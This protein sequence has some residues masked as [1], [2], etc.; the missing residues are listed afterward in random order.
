M[1]NIIFKSWK[2][3]KV[4]INKKYYW[5][6]CPK[7]SQGFGPQIVPQ[8]TRWK[9]PLINY[10]DLYIASYQPS[11]R[12]N[13]GQPRFTFLTRLLSFMRRSLTMTIIFLRPRAKKCHPRHEMELFEI[14][15]VKKT[16]SENKKA[17]AL[18]KWYC[19]K[20]HVLREGPEI[21]KKYSICF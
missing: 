13:L 8:P 12:M 18:S 17:L 15:A 11:W 21:W 16:L 7:P 19:G 6:C 20:V 10:P 2:G 4:E 5:N 3:A 9:Y 1:V 14:E